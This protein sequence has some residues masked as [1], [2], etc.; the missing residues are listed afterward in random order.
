MDYNPNKLDPA[1]EQDEPKDQGDGRNLLRHTVNRSL[2][3]HVL[4]YLNLP[5]M[6]GPAEGQARGGG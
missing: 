4:A 6:D 3:C 2:V 5:S 1:N